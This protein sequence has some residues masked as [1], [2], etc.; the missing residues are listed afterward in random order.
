MIM[1]IIT[2][3][4]ITIM[5]VFVELLSMRNMLNFAE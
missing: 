4:V 2:T 3:T 1:I 5:I